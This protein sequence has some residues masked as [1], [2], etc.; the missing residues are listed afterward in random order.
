MDI[1]VVFFPCS[2]YDKLDP[3]ILDIIRNEKD[4]YV[5]VENYTGTT[6]TGI[7]KS[8]NPDNIEEKEGVFVIKDP[9]KT[10]TQDEWYWIKRLS[11]PKKK[12]NYKQK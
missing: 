4:T 5:M 3:R 7:K 8:L 9:N 10:F 11:V 6:P 1:E 2:D 12:R